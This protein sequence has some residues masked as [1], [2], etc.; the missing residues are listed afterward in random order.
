MKRESER[1]EVEPDEKLRREALIAAAGDL[2][3]F[4]QLVQQNQ[5][6]ILADCRHMM[7]NQL[8]RKT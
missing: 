2:R 8:V 1:D 4:E 7:N 3:A 5:K 6:R